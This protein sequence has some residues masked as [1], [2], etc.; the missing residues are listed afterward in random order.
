MTLRAFC[1]INAA[2]ASGPG[3]ASKTLR[4]VAIPGAQGPNAGT[5]VEGMGNGFV[6][7]QNVTPA[8]SEQFEAGQTY[9]ITIE[10]VQGS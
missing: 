3:T 7:L 8:V 6:E 2:Q 9:D 10:P 4:F 5:F 1:Q